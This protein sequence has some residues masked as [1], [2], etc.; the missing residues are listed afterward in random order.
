MILS[1]YKKTYKDLLLNTMAIGLPIAVL[2]L[3][4]YPNLARELGSE[5][6][7]LLISIYSIWILVSS[8]LSNALIA[9]KLVNNNKYQNE[10][11]I[12]DYPVISRRW[13]IVISII[14]FLLVWIYIGR[15]SILHI[16]LGTIS[17][18]LIYYET[19]YECSFRIEINFLNILLCKIILVIGYIFGYLFFLRT[20]YWEF[21]FIFGY[22]LAFLFCYYKSNFKKESYIR[23]KLYYYI[24]KE[25]NYIAVANFIN[26]LS[27][28][29]DKLILYPLMG[30]D[31]VTVYY[32][33]TLI[34]KVISLGAN[35]LCDVILSYISKKA[36]NNKD[37]NTKALIVLFFIV[38]LCYIGVV[39]VSNGIIG[40]LY[41]QL[42]ND[43]ERYLP[44]ASAISMLDIF[45][46]IIYPFTL[47]FCSTKWQVLISLS[48]TSINYISSL[49]L[50]RIYGLVGF[51]VGAIIGQ[52]TRIILLLYVYYN[53]SNMEIELSGESK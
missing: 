4:I 19:Y 21:I 47:K 32:T 13:A 18:L 53:K 14:T 40:F 11:I 34:G 44:L 24:V 27:T 51:Y 43:V 46:T 36:S 31:V 3:F 16:L 10:G 23:T 17:A 28:Y 1:E 6:Y 2:Q 49:L 37:C 52:L 8:P 42:I 48:S 35:S 29:A 39:Y 25:F 45:G 20:K 15:F 9:V 38:V 50:W 12:G 33:S 22:G 7:G 30:G 26:N 41:P 5:K